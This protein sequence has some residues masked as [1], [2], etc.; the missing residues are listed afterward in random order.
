MLK[1]C[2]RS[3]SEQPNSLLMI[4]MIN[5]PIIQV[6]IQFKH[7]VIAAIKQDERFTVLHVGSW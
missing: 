6:G 3:Y 2:S 5:P 4:L 1:P 7:L